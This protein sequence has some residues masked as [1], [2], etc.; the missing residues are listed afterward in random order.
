MSRPASV[1]VKNRPNIAAAADSMA[2]CV[3]VN[4]KLQTADKKATTAT[5]P[6]PLAKFSNPIVNASIGI[7]LPST[8]KPAKLKL[9]TPIRMRLIKTARLSPNRA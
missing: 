5:P 3:A 8:A 9:E 2:N 6:T 4:R 7:E 1:P